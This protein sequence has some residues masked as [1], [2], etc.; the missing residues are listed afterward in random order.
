MKAVTESAGRHRKAKGR[1][2]MESDLVAGHWVS[3]PTFRT[4]AIVV[5]VLS[6]GSVIS[7]GAARR[8]T[9]AK[10][11][12]AGAGQ[13]ANTAPADAHALLVRTR[14][15]MGFERTAD[16]VVHVRISGATFQ[17]YESDRTYPPF[18][19]YFA[20]VDTWFDPKSGTE[21]SESQT[22]FPGGEGPASTT[23]S[24]TDETVMLANGKVFPVPKRSMHMR[25]LAAWAVISDWAAAPDVKFSGREVYRDYLRAV[26]TRNTEDGEQRLFLDE[27]TGFPVK[28]ELT[29][30]HYMWGQ[31]RVEYVY[32]NWML[33]EGGLVAPGSAFRLADGEAEVS[34]TVTNVEAVDRGKAPDMAM[35]QSDVKPELLPAFLRP[36]E[37]KAIRVSENTYVLSNPGYNEVVTL[38]GDDLY[39]FDAT[40][41]EERARQDAE[42]VRKLFPGEHRVYLV[43]TDLAWPHV[44][45]VRYW[46]ASG[47]TVIAHRAAE[48]FLR[49][50]I[51]RRWTLAPDT[52]ERS[53]PSARFRFVGV[54]KAYATANGKVEVY[55]IDGIG[56]EV[57][58]MV[59]VPGEHFLWASDYIQ[60]VDA[61]TEYAAE[62]RDAVQ[63][64]HIT[65]E[66][67]AAEHLAITPWS[68]VEGIESK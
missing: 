43:V 64:N 24:S 60:S 67:V 7:L 32:S 34:E 38:A 8:S 10:R 57:A 16:K 3:K 50:V 26:L 53:R 62:V 48:P 56:S 63:R 20:R 68:V 21:R 66:N 52:L 61:P 2:A 46:V 14:D 6:L 23:F 37:P 47:A 45:G 11:Y 31:R 29:E 27:K 17:N 25:N 41:G 4:A 58:L 55:P 28:L 51:E 33:F 39:V 15:A 54:D 13:S 9:P 49:K 19:S 1:E 59:Y 18:F 40:Q 22:A 5:A 30:P 44:A 35:P 12:E 36:I 42:L 65:P